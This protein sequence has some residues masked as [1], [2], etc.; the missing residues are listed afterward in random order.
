MTGFVALADWGTTSLRL[1]LIDDEGA[2]LAER[3]STEGMATATREPGGFAGV[4]D[5]HLAA[6]DAPADLPVV[7]CGMVG[8]KQGWA[9]AAYVET[10]ADPS[11]LAAGAI[12]VPEAA[13]PVFI[14]PGVCQRAEG[15]SDVMRGEETQ[16]LG[17]DFGDDPMRAER[18]LVCL[19]GTHS[20]WVT[21]ARG[22]ITGFSTFVTGDL[23]AA[24]SGHTILSHSMP[25]GDK[26]F[27]EAA[28]V[29]AARAGY[30]H[31]TEISN[32]LFAIRAGGLLE[33]ASA[34][35]AAS[36]L[37]GLLVALEIAGA[38]S[39]FGRLDGQAIRLVA[40]GALAAR[41]AAA[42]RALGLG[43]IEEDGEAAV[44]RGLFAAARKILA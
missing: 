41:Y 19:P 34:P 7:A 28:F 22:R 4:L 23:F 20:K 42:F 25:T 43:V 6:L 31:P 30:E 9:E 40:A 27:D 21:V 36:T 5:R 39:L 2:V 32:R 38:G 12:R 24:I 17:L 8:A 1:W 29:A 26:T 15:R 18:Q 3:R 13:R 10:P 16:I 11:T 35:H 14:L 44:R 37:S 33:P